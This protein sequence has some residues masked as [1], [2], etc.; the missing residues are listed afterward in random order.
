MRTLAHDK[1]GLSELLL[2]L[3]VLRAASKSLLH[4]CAIALILEGFRAIM[5]AAS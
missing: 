2:A 4:E 5:E 1:V 3:L